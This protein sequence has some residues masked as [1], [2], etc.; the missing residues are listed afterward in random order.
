MISI[1]SNILVETEYLGSNNS[2]IVT[3][4]GVVLVDSPHRPSDALRW[5]RIAEGAGTVRYLL[6]TDHHPDHTIG[7]FFMPGTVVA[8]EMTR[9]RL[10][11][12]GP[13]RQYL[14]DLFAVIDPAAQMYMANYAA[15]L[16]E[17]TFSQSL[18][19]HVGGLDFVMS[20]LPGHTLNSTLIYIPQQQVAFTGDLVCEAGLPAFIEADTFAW[21]EAV[22]VIERMDIRYIVPGHGKVTDK[23]MARI[24]RGWME[25]I[26]GEV[27]RRIDAGQSKEQIA[28][29]VTYEDRIH[30]ATGESPGYPQHLIDFFMA[31]S[32]ETIHDHILARR[33]T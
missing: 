7:N 2:I 6:N 32:I 22:K 8:H 17:I 15:R 19:L 23:S 27:G 33:A 29:E 31:K 26:V 5:R 20:H 24:F 4:E 13:T 28:R 11:S 12:V 30:I 14:D 21:I 25:D 18:T 16:P 10:I 9:E 3:R 1:D